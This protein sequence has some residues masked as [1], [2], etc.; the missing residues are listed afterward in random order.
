M[1]GACK[2]V[3]VPP[4]LVPIASHRGN[5]SLYVLNLKVFHLGNPWNDTAPP[6]TPMKVAIPHSWRQVCIRPSRRQET[7]DGETEKLKARPR[8]RASF[9]VLHLC[10]LQAFSVAKLAE[11]EAETRACVLE[12]AY[13]HPPFEANHEHRHVST[14]PAVSSTTLRFQDLCLPRELT[15]V[16]FLA[17]ALTLERKSARLER[18]KL[19]QGAGR[20]VSG[21]VLVP[22]HASGR[23][24]M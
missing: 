7:S 18:A 21:S 5:P 15:F 11:A 14:R 9:Q 3:I 22:G 4:N 1:T 2:C 10:G 20:R 23:A 24:P 12:T 6:Y 13:Q 17:L 16:A 8:Q 19:L